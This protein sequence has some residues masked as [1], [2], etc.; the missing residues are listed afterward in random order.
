MPKG[1]RAFEACAFLRHG[2]DALNQRLAG[3]SRIQPVVPGEFDASIAR[4][5]F[6]GQLDYALGVGIPQD[7]GG[8][9][10]S[11]ALS[12]FTASARRWRRSSLAAASFW[13][14][15]WNITSCLPANLLAGVT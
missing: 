2:E 15:F 6:T 13:S 14:R 10:D 7:T 12:I 4:V 1:L 5:C 11:A 9:A 3:S 8:L